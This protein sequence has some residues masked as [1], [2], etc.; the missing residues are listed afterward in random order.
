MSAP[1]RPFS[2][3]IP[4]GDYVGANRVVSS[5]NTFD[6]LS[7]EID[8]IWAGGKS[9]NDAR[10][11]NYY[12]YYF[13]GEDIKVY[14][15]GLFDP[16]DELDIQS[17]AFVVKQ[18]KTPV[19]GFWSYNFDAVMHGTRMIAGSFSV[20][21]RY[22]RRMTELLEKAAQERVNSAS[23]KSNSS[24]V[25]SLM[26]SQSE[27]L[28]DEQNLERYWG[29]SQLDRITYD[30]AVESANGRNIF[31]SHPP[32]NL[33][34]AYGVQDASLTPKTTT[35]NDS[36]GSAQ[37]MDNLDRLMA[38]DINQRTVKISAETTPMKIV[39]QNVHLTGVSMGYSTGGVPLVETYDFI[40]RDHYFTEANSDTDPYKG[41]RASVAS[42]Q[43]GDQPSRQSGGG[44]GTLIVQ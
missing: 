17:F 22:P 6:P 18:E 37:Q 39:L 34:V 23:N 3:Y 24:S 8:L 5:G 20:Y 41:L 35:K 2:G 19:Y 9:S 28:V 40:A 31:S 44:S 1:Y 42:A 30:P 13:S 12:D 43:G 7:P 11:S 33:V 32:F 29:Y 4:Y 16:K 36:S 25:V 14:I 15:D 21:T 10:F 38:T 26:R 27:S